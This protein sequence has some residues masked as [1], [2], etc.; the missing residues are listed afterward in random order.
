MRDD[1][2][3][4]DY[5]TKLGFKIDY[6]EADKRR[7]KIGAPICD[8]VSFIKNNWTIWRAKDYMYDDLVW[9]CAELKDGRFQNHR[10]F[11]DLQWALDFI[12]TYIETGEPLILRFDMMDDVCQYIQNHCKNN[13]PNV[14]SVN[15]ITF[16]MDRLDNQEIS[17]GNKQHKRGLILKEKNGSLRDPISFEIQEDE[18]RD[19]LNFHYW[20]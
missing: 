16:T 20:D 4:R 11:F 10:K 6:S 13:F 15:G 2:N 8:S 12:H 1:L 5:A 18:F 9:V 3:L 17:F 7:I 14:I 19:R